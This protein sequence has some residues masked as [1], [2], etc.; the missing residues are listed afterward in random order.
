MRRIPSKS[1]FTLAA[2]GLAAVTLLLS[3]CS[4]ATEFE[5]IDEVVEQPAN[6][7]TNVV[8]T[9]EN[10]NSETFTTG[11]TIGVYVINEDGSVSC[12]MVEVDEDGNAA[13]PATGQGSTMVA[14]S[15]YQEE[16]G[17]SA[18]V[19][20]PVFT[21]QDNQTKEES[22]DA[23]DLMIGVSTSK[24]RTRADISPMTF[25][26]MLA[27]VAIHVV[28]ETGR[29]NLNAIN[30]ELLSLYSSV[31]VDL[32]H[33][34]VTTLTDVR[35]NIRMLS[36]MTTDWRISSYGIVSPQEVAD[37]TEFYAISLFGNRQTYP[38][39]EGTTLEGGKTYT[40]NMRLTEHGLIPDGW[41]IGDWDDEAENSIDVKVNN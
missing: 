37:G 6:G 3:A 12:Q 8:V 36:E 40:I 39:P 35:T 24:A 4:K 9:D 23:S 13:L 11:T 21:V 41:T 27:K 32:L 14:Y 2:C 10:G 26:H 30:A 34:A 7:E 31:Q 15:P 5:Y 1:R 28:D 17:D 25:S 33:Q 19:T 20:N 18:I 38:I 22:Y 29:V 16:W